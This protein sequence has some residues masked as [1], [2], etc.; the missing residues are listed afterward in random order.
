MTFL[1]DIENVSEDL[2]TAELVDVSQYGGSNPDR[3]ELALYVYLYKRDAQENDTQ[4]TVDNNNPLTA[5]AWSFVL[6]AADGVFVAIVFGIYVW[7]AGTYPSG[8]ARYYNGI[9]YISNTSTSS[10]PGVDS[11]WDVVSDILGELSGNTTVEETQTYN[12]SAAHSE[13]GQ[14]GDAIA[15]FAPSVLDGRCK[16]YGKA[17]KVL[18]GA[19]LIES[20]FV[21]FRRA[22]YVQAQTSIDFVQANYAA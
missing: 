3:D 12:W 14:L 21:N 13:S 4:I 8:T 2:S 1:T 18:Y 19:A 7:S 16:D 22:D 17:A 11:T 10:T 5:N 6:P 15:D 20:A 9:Y